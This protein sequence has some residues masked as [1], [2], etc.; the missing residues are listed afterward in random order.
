MQLNTYV[1]YKGDCD[2]AFKFYEQVLGA[3]IEMR[4]T[5]GDSPAGAQTPADMKDRIIHA[6]IRIGDTILMGSDAP[7]ERYSPPA[8]FSLTLGLKT[9]EEAE[10]TFAALSAGGQVHMPLMESFFAHRFGMLADKF[11]MPWMIICEKT[12]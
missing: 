1:H 8:G 4:Q 7:A 11:G 3:R 12:P 6:R 2:A 9:I 10:K 5:Y